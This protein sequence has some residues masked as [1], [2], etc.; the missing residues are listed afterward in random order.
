MPLAI[1]LALEPTGGQ[2]NAEVVRIHRDPRLTS[3]P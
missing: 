1:K 3:K 2:E